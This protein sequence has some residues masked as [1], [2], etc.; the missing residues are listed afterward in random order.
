MDSFINAVTDKILNPL[1]LL[2]FGIALLV[3]IWGLVK[4]IAQG[5]DED[6]RT[7]AKRHIIYG[8]IGMAIMFSAFALVRLITGVFGIDTSQNLDQL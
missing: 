3:F 8:L 4:F 2:L 6:V 7:T 1:I 5:G